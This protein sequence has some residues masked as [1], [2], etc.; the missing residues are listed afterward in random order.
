MKLA[1][2]IMFGI[3]AGLLSQLLYPFALRPFLLATIWFATGVACVVVA[4]CLP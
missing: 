1:I 4:L 2:A 3:T